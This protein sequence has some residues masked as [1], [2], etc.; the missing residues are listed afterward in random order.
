MTGDEGRSSYARGVQPGSRRGRPGAESPASRYLGEPDC[1][2]NSIA[3]YWAALARGCIT[4]CDDEPA[5]AGPPASRMSTLGTK[6]PNVTD[7]R[8][9]GSTH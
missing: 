7:S 2:R 5:G 4:S 3:R 8:S 9:F 6:E 1:P